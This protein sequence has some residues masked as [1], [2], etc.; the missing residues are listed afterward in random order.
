MWYMFWGQVTDLD[1][2][3]HDDTER[4]IA[5]KYLLFFQ[6]RHHIGLVQLFFILKYFPSGGGHAA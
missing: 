6:N 1:G 2:S 5:F 4:D 3:N